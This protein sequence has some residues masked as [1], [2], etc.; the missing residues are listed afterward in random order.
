LVD[1]LASIWDPRWREAITHDVVPVTMSTDQSILLGLV[2]T[3]LLTNAVKYAYAG[4]P[5]PVLIQA[6]QGNDGRL[7]L[8]VADRGTGLASDEPRQSFGSHLV[9]TL[10]GQLSGTVERADNDPGLRL[11]LTFPLEK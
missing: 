3:E 8:V 1:E 9:E 4:G 11:I 6:T 10:V 5:G 7:R 2:V